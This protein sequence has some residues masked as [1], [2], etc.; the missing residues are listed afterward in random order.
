[1]RPEADQPDGPQREQAQACTDDDPPAIGAAGCGERH[2][3]QQ[4]SRADLDSHAHDQRHRGG[5]EARARPR[6]Q[7]QGAPEQEQDQRVVVGAAHGELEQHRVQAHEGRGKAPGVP[8]ASGG[9]R[10]QRHGPEARAHRHGLERPQAACDAQGARRVA[11][12]GEERPV[13]GALERPADEREDRI[14]EG[15]GREVRVGVQAVKAAHAREGQ[16]AE[17]VL[18]D[19]RRAEQQDQL[20]RHDRRRQQPPGKRSGGEQHHQVARAHDQHE[21]LEAILGETHFEAAKRPGQPIR[22]AAAAGR[23]V[24]RGACRGARGDQEHAA[25][26]TDQAQAPACRQQSRSGPRPPRRVGRALGDS[27]S[28]YGGCR[29]DQ[30]IV[31]SAGPASML[32]AR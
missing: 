22:P 8:E 21:R 28:R 15:F 13:G 32:R 10:D 29:L 17:D 3:R 24:H 23:D 7:C 31:T 1:V 14:V 18:G 2:E 27:G 5:S 20:D 11:R 4:K 30:P 9:P 12:E 6:R 25:Q 26:H 16:V 19:Q